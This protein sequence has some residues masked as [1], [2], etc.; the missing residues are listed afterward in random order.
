MARERV[1][2]QGLGDAVPGIQPTI[3]RG[4][5]YSVQ[6]QRAGR[7]KLMDL[8]DALGQV[9]PL[10]Q[11]YGGLQKQQEQIGVEQAELVEEQNVIAE[12]KK[13]KDVDGFSIL[14]TTNRDRAYR[15]ALLKRHI[16]STMLP[17]LQAK[18]ADLVNAETYKDRATFLQGVDKTFQEEWNGLVSQVGED[19]ANSTAGKA[20]W[21]YVTTPYKNKLALQYEEQKQKVIE[22]GHQ[23]ELAISLSAATRDKGFDTSILADIASNYEKLFAD[24]G[25]DKVKRNKLLVDGYAATVNQLYAK[26]RFN[27]AKRVLDSIGTIRINDKP[28]FGSKEA[29]RQ[30]TPLLSKVNT[31]LVDV[32]TKSTAQ[33]ADILKG[34]LFSVMSSGIKNK[35]D[36]PDSKINVLKAVFTD[37]N[38]TMEPERVNQY[39]EKVFKGAGDIGQNLQTV[40]EEV[41]LNEGDLADTLYF[42]IIDDVIRDYDKIQSVGVT[43]IRITPENESEVLDDFRRYVKDNPEED[44]PWK[45]Y[46]AQEGGRIPKFEKLIEESEL[47]T[48][49]NYVLKKG[50]YKDIAS[51]LLANLGSIDEKLKD[52][53]IAIDDRSYFYNSGAV[54]YIK[55]E[56]KKEAIRL[57]DRDEDVRDA[58][59]EDLTTSL[60]IEERKRYEGM[61]SASAVVYAKDQIPPPTKKERT[62]LEQKYKTMFEGEYDESRRKQIPALRR[63]IEID[64]QKMFEDSDILALRRSLS[65]YGYNGF[66]PNSYKMLQKS[67]LDAADVKLFANLSELN[68]QM[69]EF[70]DV[71]KK[72][73]MREELSDAEKA[74]KETYQGLGIFDD[75]S[76]DAFYN[77]QVS[78]Y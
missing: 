36:M 9:N 72:D 11:Q 52:K 29:L 69:I 38:P 35:E 62:Q 28:V 8:A 55:N 21:D 44:T 6:V 59:L 12:L 39:I 31:Q 75:A 54:S 68:R 51:S 65:R 40:L 66:D 63:D 2:V 77:A 3:Q 4:G 20:L 57:K 7:N 26:R 10:L 53:D 70:D 24:S 43:P 16:N 71:L 15:D 18:E 48:A 46:I 50:Y 34:R 32:S 76:Y 60:I 45:G 67:Q 17:S 19:V 41:A 61:A 5:Q 27:D 25:I 56:V 78:Y 1:Q 14:A 73:L 74:L 49:G 64:R 33:Q 30:L 13:Q 47:L 42:K 23:D 37:M 58:A 22:Q